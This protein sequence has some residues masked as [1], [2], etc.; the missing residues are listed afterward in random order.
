MKLKVQE[1]KSIEDGAHEGIID[2]VRYRTEPYEY[3][4]L[5]IK[6]EGG[7]TM[8]VGYPTM[9]SPVSKLGMML[10]SFGVELVFGE[11]IDIGELLIGKGVKFVT[12]TENKPNG[13]FAKIVRESVKPNE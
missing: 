6:F 5:V 13:K 11:E 2:D 12:M 8:T 7:K 9:L 3:T 10:Q 4:D 1:V